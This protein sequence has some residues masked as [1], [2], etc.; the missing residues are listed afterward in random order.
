[1]T[2]PNKITSIP[3]PLDIEDRIVMLAQRDRVTAEVKITQLL[4]TSLELEE[5]RWL[6]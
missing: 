2:T 5:D 1:M 3:L 4:E 6:T